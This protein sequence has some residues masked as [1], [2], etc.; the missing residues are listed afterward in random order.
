VTDSALQ[1]FATALAA[2]DDPAQRERMIARAKML[3]MNAVPEEKFEAPVRTLGEYLDTPIPVPPSL[4]WPTICVRGEIT[5]TLGRAGKGKTTLN[6]NRIMAWAAGKPLFPA[7]MNKDNQVYLNPSGPL[8]TL[9]VENEGNAGMFH[10]KMGV[11]LAKGKMKDSPDRDAVRENLLVYGDGGYSGL[12]LDDEI[13]LNS[14]R[15]ACERWEPDIVFI[16]PFRGL[17]KGEENSSTDMAIVVDNLQALA[18]D[19]QCAVILSHHE[20]KS[21]VGD[22]GE[23]MSAGR[24]STVL[25]GAAAVM[26]NFESAVAGEFRELSWSKARYLQPPTTVRMKY[27]EESGWYEHIADDRLEQLIMEHLQKFDESL[28]KKELMEVSDEKEARVREALN[29]LVDNNRI[30]RM[31]GERN[32]YHYRMRT[33]DEESNGGLSL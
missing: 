9:I 11:L 14:V 33:T 5:V 27:G 29:Q 26:E 31:K 15:S 25:E 24:G 3:A 10:Q 21:G 30:V 7:F 28:T 8:K 18:T 6:L 1:Q 19:Y 20:R 32:E 22:D 2:V 12:K 4:V 17:W 16:E 13:G 23:K